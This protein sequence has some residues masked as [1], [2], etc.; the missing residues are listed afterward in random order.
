MNILYHHRTLGDGAEGIHIREMV[1]AFRQ[2]GHEVAVA[3][4]LG[5]Q[6]PQEA[7]RQGLLSSMKK[8][9]PRQ[10]FELLEISYSLYCLRELDG[11]IRKTRP[12]FVYDRY[13]TF[14]AGALWAARRHNVPY[15]LEVNAPLALERSSE[16]DEK[17]HLKKLA[18]FF[19]RYICSNADRTIVVSSPLRDYLESAGVP[20]HKCLVMPNGVDQ[21]KFVPRPAN[22]E[23]AARLKV[24]PGMTVIGFTGILRPWHGLEM[25]IRAVG[26]LN[27]KGKKVFLLIVGDGP[28]RGA[29]EKS[30]VDA[31]LGGCSRITGKV[32]HEEVA[33]YVNLFD[34]AVSPKATFYASPMKVVEYMSLGKAVVVPDTDNFRDL[35][36]GGVNGVLFRRDCPESL[37]ACLESLCDSSPLRRQ[38]G[39]MAR[40]KVLM[41]LNWKWNARE[42]CRLVERGV[43]TAVGSTP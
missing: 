10:L 25:L 19:E 3:G 27:A 42:V 39:A 4:P 16:P 11:R 6:R 9:L 21:D 18:H 5:E 41:R 22:R 33:D 30:L 1:R 35:V 38:I 24:E 14:N 20:P 17:L 8:H 12:D 31:G 26:E 7:G 36:D 40:G 43:H 29:I 34:I 23:L 32:P 28:V 13:I 15:I 37:A 2:L